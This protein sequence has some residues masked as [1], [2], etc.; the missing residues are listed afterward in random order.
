[1]IMKKF[2]V[3]C[4]S[5][6]LTSG[7]LLSGCGTVSA[8]GTPINVVSREEGSG[9]RGAFIELF[10]V[11]VRDGDAR[12]DMTTSEANFVNKTDI[13]LT[14][15]AGDKNAVGYVSLGSLNDSIKA[16]A[17]NGVAATSANVKNG[18]Y[19]IK[20]PFNIAVKGA[21][22]GLTADFIN[23]I[24]SAEGQ[25]VVGKDYVAIMENAAPFGGT[26]P[27]GTLKIEGSSSVSPV[28]EKLVEAY[29]AINT[30]AK[31]EMQTTD[32]S[33][34]MTAAMDGSCD[35]GMASRDLKDSEKEVLT[36]ISIAIDGIAVI[37]NKDNACSELTKEQVRQIFTGEFTK[38]GDIK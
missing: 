3:L 6:V 27:E 9:T 34:G 16:V 21:A 28:M 19:I 32:S 20:R 38:W 8:S 33:A 25:A 15:V 26:L 14:T 12:K 36:E 29:K 11:E 23:Y 35:I 5:A 31:I 7:L 17:I 30:N 13:M 2:I 1:M 37:V 18:S 24:L 10:G 22:E 4:L